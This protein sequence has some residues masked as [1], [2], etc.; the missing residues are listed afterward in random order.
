MLELKDKVGVTAAWT[1]ARQNSAGPNSVINDAV[2]ALI[3]LG[4]K[5]VEAVKA[6][7]KITASEEDQVDSDKLIRAALR[8]MK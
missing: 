2:L 4:Y 8:G 7:E 3:S 5:Q 6:V 1:V